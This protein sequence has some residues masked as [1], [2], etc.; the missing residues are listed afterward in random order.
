M[1]SAQHQ[2]MTEFVRALSTP[3]FLLRQ[4]QTQQNLT[5][6]EQIMWIHSKALPTAWKIL[7]EAEIA[8]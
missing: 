4:K 7:E 2:L 3:S 1:T 8:G 6:W 5:S